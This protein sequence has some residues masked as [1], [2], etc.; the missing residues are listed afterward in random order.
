MS[1]PISY[2][3]PELA[4]MRHYPKALYHSGSLELLGRPKISIVGTRRPSPYTRAMT[5]E[6]SKKLSLSGMVVVSGAAGGVDAIAHAGAGASN[7]IA[8]MPCG[9][10][11]RYPASNKGLIEGIE[12]QGLLLSPFEKGFM[13]RDWSF[14]VRNEIV[15]ALGDVLIVTEAGIGSGSMRSVEYALAMNKPIY[16]LPHRLH[17]SMA[18]R[19]LLR[20]GKATAIDDMNEF[21]AHI[22]QKGR[23]AVT[24]SPFIA[25]CRQNPIYEEAMVAYPSEIFESE[26][27]GVIEVRNGRV[28][29]V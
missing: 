23:N 17:E 2:V 28:S 1:E 15:V 14:V 24:D 25:F 11:I 13:A 18:T 7:T 12:K 4:S 8:V 9:V 21:V 10:D 27:S 29:V 22:S 26:L 20:E 6:L 3:I 16:V 5:F 19:Q